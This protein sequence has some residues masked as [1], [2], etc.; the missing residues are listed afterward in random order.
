[1]IEFRTLGGVDLSGP[2]GVELRSI[3]SQSKRLALLAYL[4][5]APADS[6][7]RDTLVA[8]LWPAGDQAHARNA[9][10]QTLHLLRRSLGEGVLVSHGSEQVSLSPD[11]LWCDAAAFEAALDAG[12]LHTA[13]ELYRGDFLNGVHVS[14]APDF[15]RWLDDERARLRGRALTA[16]RE[17]ADQEE[18][19]GNLVGAVSSLRW[20]VRVAPWEES[21]TSRLID[22][23]GQAGDRSGAIRTYEVFASQLRQEYGV[24]PSPELQA[25]VEAV[26]SSVEGI[27]PGPSGDERDDYTALAAPAPRAVS[28]LATG[29]IFRAVRPSSPRRVAAWMLVAVP[30]AVAGGYLWTRG[31]DQTA[32]AGSFEAHR[33]YRRAQAAY[34]SRQFDSALVYLERSVEADSTYAR[35]WALLG[36][37]NVMLN[38]ENRGQ[39]EFLLPAAMEAAQRAIDLDSALATAWHTYATVEWS[40]LR[41]WTNAERDYSRALSLCSGGTSEAQ[42]ARIRAN[43]TALLADLGRCDEAREV[44][45]PYDDLFPL[46]RGLTSDWMIRIPYLCNDYDAAIEEAERTLAAGDSSFTVLQLLFLARLET[47]D[48]KAAEFAIQRLRQAWP[49]RHYSSQAL[50]GLLEARRGDLIAAL[51]IIDELEQVEPALAFEGLDRAPAEPRAQL[52]ASVGDTDE[53]FRVLFDEIEVKGHIRRLSSHPLFEPLR[54]D[55]RY[56][57]LLARMNLRCRSSVDRHI[58]QPLD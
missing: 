29:G 52:Y 46:D 28:R 18:N 44:I 16:A 49:D 7:R 48:L 21:L 36:Y 57:T 10:N 50:Q 54:N 24:E 34:E 40:Y 13:V 22:L 15:E 2:G 17:L 4:A 6:H 42:V 3:L 23:L 26:R 30:L 5:A 41:D 33:E 51:S 43:L 47:G 27:D 39:A 58:C 37:T 19:A 32:A 35:A 12:D 20:A 31:I 25:L 56:G 9:L 53:A 8:L 11:S 45:A 38:L 1:V 55:P 14:D